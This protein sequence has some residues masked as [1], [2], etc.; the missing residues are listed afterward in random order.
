MDMLIEKIIE[1]VPATTLN[2]TTLHALV[3]GT[4]DKRY[5]LVKRALKKGELVHL[6]RG[7]YALSDKWRQRPINLYEAAQKIYGPSYISLETALSHHGWIPEAV[8]TVTSVCFKRSK[9]FDTPL[10]RFSYAH[11]P[12]NYFFAGVQR[13]SS[14]NSVFL[15]ATPW[16]SLADYVY[17]HQKNWTSLKPV[18]KDLRVDPNQFQNVDVSL[19]NEIYEA[20]RSFRVKKFIEGIQKELSS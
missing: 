2:D 7:L 5:G 14:A 15:M 18:L 12:S 16:R 13:I 19:L 10:G 1:K 4:D 9:E 3:P 17:V 6:K 8:Y 20:F 11:I